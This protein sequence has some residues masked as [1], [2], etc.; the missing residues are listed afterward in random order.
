[1]ATLTDA[2]VDRIESGRNNRPRKASGFKSPSKVLLGTQQRAAL[3]SRIRPVQIEPYSHSI[4][5]GGL[6]LMS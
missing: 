1:M 2:V 5:A 3:Q 6:P 4:V